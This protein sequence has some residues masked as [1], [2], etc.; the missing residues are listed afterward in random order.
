MAIN[1]INALSSGINYIALATA[2]RKDEEM[3]AYHS[4]ISGLVL[5]D[6]Q[7]GPTDSTLLCNVS[8]GQPMPIIPAAWH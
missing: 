5:E 1:A 2:Q 3:A 8:T 4:A 7:F 6:E